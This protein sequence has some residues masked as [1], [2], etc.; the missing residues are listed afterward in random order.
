MKLGKAEG[1]PEEIKNFFE[2][3]GLNP[4]DYFEKTEN[5]LH[6]KWIAIP[7]SVVAISLLLF[8]VARQRYS[9][10]TH[11][12]VFG[13]RWLRVLGSC[14]FADQVQKWLGYP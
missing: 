14:I 7:V 12:L 2:N 10:D 1:T 4:A 13:W 9:K 5:P 8:G 3:H 6:W 11:S